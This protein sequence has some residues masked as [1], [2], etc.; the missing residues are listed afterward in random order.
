MCSSQ[1]GSLLVAFLWPKNVLCERS[2]FCQNLIR[3]ITKKKS[4]SLSAAIIHRVN[5][6]L[7]DSFVGHCYYGP[8]FQDWFDATLGISVSV[9]NSCSLYT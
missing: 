9:Y 8:H 1:I 4:I 3:D 5:L 6:F 2:E 7:A